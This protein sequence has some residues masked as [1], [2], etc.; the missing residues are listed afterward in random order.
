MI[1]AILRRL[2]RDRP[3]NIIPV[4]SKVVVEVAWSIRNL[5]F[6]PT[7]QI[8]LMLE[9]RNSA[10]GDEQPVVIPRKNVDLPGSAGKNLAVQRRLEDPN[11]S[12][13]FGKE[14][15]PY[16]VK[17]GRTV[18]H[19]FSRSCVRS[20]N[21]MRSHWRDVGTLDAYRASNIDLI[22]IWPEPRRA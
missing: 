4:R 15:I 13:G 14:V 9:I 11:P 3:A 2:K 20:N 7:R 19:H 21:D 8:D 17:R 22:D 6:C 16:I 12:H 5:S 10:F 18:A 1:P